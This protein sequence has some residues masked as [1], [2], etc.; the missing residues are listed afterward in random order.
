MGQHQRG[1]VDALDDLGHGVRLAAAGDA[2]EH[3]RAQAVF[4]ALRQLIDSLGLVAGGLIFRN[5]FQIRHGILRL[6]RQQAAFR[7]GDII[8]VS[9]H[10]V[11]GQANVQR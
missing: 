6:S 9:H 7:H 2:L 3:L 1:P 11:V 10:H 8:A 5:D 4:Q